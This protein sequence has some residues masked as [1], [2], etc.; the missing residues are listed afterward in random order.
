MGDVWNKMVVATYDTQKL[1]GQTDDCHE[2]TPS[3]QS[4]HGA[5]CETETSRVVRRSVANCSTA[6][7][8]EERKCVKI[9]SH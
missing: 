2:N 3:V 1:R 8:G 9:V 5:R 4:V 6:T 7:Q